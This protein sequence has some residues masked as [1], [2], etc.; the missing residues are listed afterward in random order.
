MNSSKFFRK[1][2]SFFGTPLLKMNPNTI[3]RLCISNK[4][5]FSLKIQNLKKDLNDTNISSNIINSLINKN[6]NILENIQNDEEIQ[7]IINEIRNLSEI[8][9][10]N[11][12]LLEKWSENVKI[13]QK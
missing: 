6:S 11:Q 10:L 2:R 5:H 7:D 3:R 12:N 4:F 13:D 1:S 8:E 9:I